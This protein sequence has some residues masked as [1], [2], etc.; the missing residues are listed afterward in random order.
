ML[1]IRISNWEVGGTKIQTI[2]MEVSKKQTNIQ[3][4][5][6]KMF[7]GRKQKSTL[8]HWILMYLDIDVIY[9]TATT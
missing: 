6:S 3:K 1:G 9:K 7:D 2:A 5:P 4:Q 8:S